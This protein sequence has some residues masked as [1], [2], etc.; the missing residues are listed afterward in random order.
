MS[1]DTIIGV[2]SIGTAVLGVLVTFLIGLQ[3]WNVV[4]FEKRVN[5][6]IKDVVKLVEVEINSVKVNATASIALTNIALHQSRGNLNAMFSLFI[7]MILAFENIKDANCR[8]YMDMLFEAIDMLKLN[9]IIITKEENK[10]AKETVY[11]VAKTNSIDE[12]FIQSLIKKIDSI[13]IND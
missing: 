3:I 7:Q 10:Y 2:I 13:Q 12:Y 8:R 1:V 4:T 6:K 11:K 5:N 9:G